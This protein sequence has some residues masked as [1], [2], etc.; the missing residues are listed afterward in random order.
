VKA[1]EPEAD[2]R[3]L[4]EAA[5]R[6][7]SRF[8]ELYE[9]NFAR[10]Y[11]YVVRRVHARHEAE[12]VT[13]EVFHRA[14]ANLDRFEWRGAPFAAWLFRIAAHAI[15]DRGQRAA[16]ERL[17]AEPE[18]RAAEAVP[19]DIGRHA[20]LY[21]QVR[22]LPEDHS[23]VELGDGGEAMPARPAAIHLYVPDAV[24][25]RAVAAGAVTLYAPADMPYGDREAGV[26]DPSGNNWYIG[27][28]NLTMK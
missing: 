9:A 18:E 14:L 17:V 11:A 23:V 16:R 4:I 5:Q 19:P 13:S 26:R 12:D 10:V 28:R 15:A 2:E 20:R 21:Q 27:T 24:H 25:A 1:T 7:P 3:R 8:A 6:D 22:A